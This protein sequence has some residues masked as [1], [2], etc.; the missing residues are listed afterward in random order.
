MDCVMC[1]SKVDGFILWWAGQYSEFN[2]IYVLDHLFIH[3][4]DLF[5]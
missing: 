2:I 1:L 3:G 4:E 5:G